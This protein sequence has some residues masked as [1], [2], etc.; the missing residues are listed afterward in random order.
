MNNGTIVLSG[1]TYH[2]KVLNRHVAELV[3]PLVGS[4]PQFRLVARATDNPS[5]ATL[6][7]G[8][9][10]AEMFLFPEAI[11]EVKTLFPGETDSIA[12]TGKA[13][14]AVADGLRSIQYEDI[15]TDMSVN[16]LWK[17]G[18][19]QFVTESMALVGV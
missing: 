17:D 7:P 5:G 10:V 4:M 6:A 16:D 14:P 11:N 15:L 13:G 1:F 3:V 9:P 2:L 18:S 12:L 8:T 19:S